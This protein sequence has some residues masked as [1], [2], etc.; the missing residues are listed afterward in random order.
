VN[1]YNQSDVSYYDLSN[2]TIS[3]SSG[4]NKVMNQSEVAGPKL[5]NS[6]F[7]VVKVIE[8]LDS[9]VGI[10]FLDK[11]DFL[12]IE[13]NSGKVKR[14][15][16]GILLNQLILD[17]NVANVNER[18]LVGIAISKNNSANLTY[19]FLYLTESR[20]MDGEDKCD[21][22]Y[23]CDPERNYLG[24]KLYRYEFN[25]NSLINPKLLFQVPPS[26]WAMHNGGKIVIDENNNL[27]LG[28]GDL[29]IP[30]TLANNVANGTAPYGTGGIIR[31][32]Q[33]GTGVTPGI[34]GDEYPYHF[35]YAY[36]IRNVFGLGFDPLTG[37]LWDT[38]NGPGFGDEVNLVRPGFNSGWAEV[39]GNR[40]F[41]SYTGGN[42]TLNPVNLTTLNEIGEYS[43]PELATDR[44]TLAPTSLNFVNSTKYGDAYENDMIVSVFNRN[45]T[46]YHFDL[47]NNRTELLLDK[48]NG[49]EN[50]TVSTVEELNPYIFGEDFGGIVDLEVSPDGYL[51]VVS[52]DQNAVFK[53]EPV[54]NTCLDCP[55]SL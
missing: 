27:Y 42:I 49:I 16:D 33:N 5:V 24:N 43:S 19:V 22:L 50:E 26:I 28:I 39:S 40:E 55:P 10:A 36:G 32:T 47:T 34:F 1:T 21:D 11:D 4:E 9:P 41:T 38:E 54:G 3:D 53:I 30:L 52:I 29:S 31:I 14:V 25:N 18:G 46:L 6:T 20:N 48:N 45:G 15:M 51:Y 12:V 7:K 2:A 23:K 8:G 13:K 17:L 44:F 37:N 35:Y